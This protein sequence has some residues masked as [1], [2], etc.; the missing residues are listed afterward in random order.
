[1]FPAVPAGFEG[2]FENLG[3]QGAFVVS[4]KRTAGGVEF[5]KIAS[6]A[7]NPCTVANPWAGRSVLVEDTASGKRIAATATDGRIQFK[8]RRGRTY[9][10]GASEGVGSR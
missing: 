2:G 10:L 1:V 3:A 5:L 4:A 9:R 6:L 8:T 7:G